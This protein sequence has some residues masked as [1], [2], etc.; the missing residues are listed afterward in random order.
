MIV[1]DQKW[2]EAAFVTLLEDSTLGCIW[3][4]ESG[5]VAA[6]HAVLTLQYTME[7]GLSS[8]PA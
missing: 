5:G 1:L 2:A 3:I 8:G 7:H 4:A 6:G